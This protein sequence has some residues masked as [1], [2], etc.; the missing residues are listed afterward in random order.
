MFYG[1]S[2]AIVALIIPIALIGFIIS[3]IV[4]KNK[5]SKTGFE[6]IVRN[7]YTYIVLI[8]TL[9]AIIVGTISLFR[10]GLDI[11]LP[12]KMTYESS[13][14][15]YERNKNS[16]IIEL[17][18]ELAIVLSVIPVFIYHNNIAKKSREVKADIQENDID[19]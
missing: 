1:I 2:V 12:E 11:I 6:E 3:A 5:D 18:T 7:I 4:K 8:I 13:S 16:N 9:I 14:Y 17:F 15:V 19:N 10:V